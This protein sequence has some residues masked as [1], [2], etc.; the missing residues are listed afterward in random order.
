[1]DLVIVILWML[2][3]FPF[4]V[5]MWNEHPHWIAILLVNGLFGWTGIGWIGALLWA[6]DPGTPRAAPEPIARR[7][8]L[9]LLPGGIGPPRSG[10]RDTER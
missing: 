2:Y 1:V 4:T 7:E 9:R 8:H 6:R 5:A 10:D 3:F